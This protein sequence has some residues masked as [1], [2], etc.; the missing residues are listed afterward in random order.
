MSNFS[1][2][3]DL[4]LIVHEYWVSKNLLTTENKGKISFFFEADGKIYTSDPK[5]IKSKEHIINNHYIEENGIVAVEMK[6]YQLSDN[7]KS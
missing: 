3:C 2:D 7:S 4:V 5:P 1:E 6:H